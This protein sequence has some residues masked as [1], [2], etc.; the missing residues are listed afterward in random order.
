MAGKATKK[1]PEASAEEALT[2]AKKARTVSRGGASTVRGAPLLRDLFHDLN[3]VV[4]VTIISAKAAPQKSGGKDRH[5]ILGEL[6]GGGKVQDTI[7]S[8]SGATPV[9]GEQWTFRMESLEADKRD[10][11]I[12]PPVGS[13]N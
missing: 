12:N 11:F 9:K 7:F 6:A 3:Q 4:H 8:K 2:Q 10:E 5:T 13:R 1:T